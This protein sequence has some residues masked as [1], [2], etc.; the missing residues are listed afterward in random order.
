VP[1]WYQ[2]LAGFLWAVF[3]LIAS[4]TAWRFFGF[5]A[6]CYVGGGLLVASVL[7]DAYLTFRRRL[8]G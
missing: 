7:L 6:L 2:V 3:V 8:L 4:Y 1:Y 5:V